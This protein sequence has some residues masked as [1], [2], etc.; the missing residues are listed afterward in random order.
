M[1]QESGVT[2]SLGAGS[3]DYDKVY[4]SGA[5]EVLKLEPGQQQEAMDQ[6]IAKSDATKTADIDPRDIPGYKWKTVTTDGRKERIQVP[7]EAYLAEQEAA[8]QE[9]AP[10]APLNTTTGKAS[11]GKQE[12]K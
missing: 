1:T 5:E 7:D 10:P 4:G 12:G 11:G 3:Y 9:L 8:E 6:L 2:A